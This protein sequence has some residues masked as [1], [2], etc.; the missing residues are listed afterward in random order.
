MGINNEELPI[1][2]FRE[3]IIA[4]VHD[5][6]VTLIVGSTGCGKTTQVPQ[7]LLDA[8]FGEHGIIGCT[9][10]RRAAATAIARYVARERKSN[11]G[12]EVGYHVR[13]E[14]RISE[15]TK[16]KFATSGI[17]LRETL[18]DPLLSFYSCVI[19]DEAH[20]RD[21]FNDFLLGYLW[22]VCGE[23]PAFRLVVMSATLQWQA[24]ARFFPG[25]CIIN[26]PQRRFPVEIV[27]H[28]IRDEEWLS[29][30]LSH[31]REVH[32]SNAQ[33]DI[34]VF[35]SGERDVRK[36]F[37]RVH[38]LSLKNL[39][40]FPLYGG[41]S[42]ERQQEVFERTRERKVIVA[43]NVAESSLTFDG[44]VIDMGT[45]KA[46]GFDTFFGIE[47]LDLTKISKSS[48]EQRAGRVGRIGPGKC[49]RL[50]SEDDF[51]ARPRYEEPE[52][53][54]SDL[55]NLVLIMKCLGLKNDFPFLTKPNP[56]LWASAQEQLRMYG[57]LDEYGG[58]TD[59]GRKMA[60]MPLDPYLSHFV[61]RSIAWGC[62][63]DAATL[64][65][66]LSLGRFFY[67]ELYEDEESERAQKMF[68]DEESDFFTLLAIWDAY[69]GA[70]YDAAWCKQNSLHVGWMN[71]VRTTR[72][73]ILTFLS[74]Q[75]AGN[76]TSRNRETLGKAIL[77]GF[78][79]NLLRYHRN[80]R[81]RSW[82]SPLIAMLSPASLLFERSPQFVV[83]S[84][85]FR[86]SAIFAHCNHAVPYE[87]VREIVP[88]ALVW[89]TASPQEHTLRITGTLSV[90]QAGQQKHVHVDMDLA[91]SSGRDLVLLDRGTALIEEEKYPVSLLALHGETI[92]A[93]NKAGIT[94]LAE[95]PNAKEELTAR[96]FDGETIQDIFRGIRRLGYVA[97][98]APFK[99]HES[100]TEETHETDDWRLASF[101][102][103]PLDALKCSSGTIIRLWGVDIRTVEDLVKK[104]ED[105]LHKKLRDFF[106]PSEHD[107]KKIAETMRDVRACLARFGLSLKAPERKHVLS[108][109][110]DLL[111]LPSAT[112][113]DDV[114]AE[115]IL[116]SEQFPLFKQYRVGTPPEKIE[117]RNALTVTNKGLSNK[118]VGMFLYQSRV[119]QDPAIDGDDLFQEGIIGLMR[120]I[121]TFDYTLGGRFS[122]YAMWWIRQAME[123]M[124]A[125]DALMRVPVHM[126]EKIQRL[127]KIAHKLG[128][129]PTREDVAKTMGIRIEEVARIQRTMLFQMHPTSILR[130]PEDGPNAG[131]FDDPDNVE[132]EIPDDRSPVLDIIAEEQLKRF[133]QQL[134]SERIVRD[135]DRTCLMQ[136]FGL[137]GDRAHTLEEIG[138]Y[139]GVTRERVRQRIERALEELR[140]RDVWEEAKKHLP[141]IAQVSPKSVS[142]FEVH[143]GEKVDEL[144]RTRKSKEQM[145]AECMV[146][147]ARAHQVDIAFLNKGKDI[148]RDLIPVRDHAVY[149]LVRGAKMTFE[150]VA[151]LFSLDDAF[152]AEAAYTCYIEEEKRGKGDE[153]KHLTPD[154]RW[155][156]IS[157]LVQVASTFGLTSEEIVQRGNRKE[158][159]YAGDLAIYRMREEARLSFSQIGSVMSKDRMTVIHGYYQVKREKTRKEDK[160]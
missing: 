115:E 42:P 124:V 81:Y 122:T 27:Y 146:A 32:Q 152:D 2:Q 61:L 6:Q 131:R 98:N 68:R 8:G 95:L 76:D 143:V 55:G 43:T 94:K 90:E 33:G 129:A 56:E 1:A 84:R 63:K 88:E 19:V 147:V 57:A 117:A 29:A 82:R 96:G 13:L 121:E 123:R 107:K 148:P 48:A 128:E 47:T 34:L 125:D 85:L 66:M 130:R 104:T 5:H 31:I 118:V 72:E 58:L 73:Q 113:I 28:P 158:V 112:P 151:E 101:L 10:P 120:S 17:V 153:E 103:Q 80:G 110:K 77:D 20:E 53:A 45:A 142:A 114:A 35:V 9:E 79:A 134:I 145:A 93:L 69:E 26:I 106:D 38:E 156:A 144:V 70:S 23:R 126:V 87:W 12:D 97:R 135:A 105:E 36:L 51:H 154:A 3:K 78:R 24:F 54:R 157:I 37:E 119:V 159:V 52:I 133:V 15:R 99:K 16:L 30:T 132:Y 64:A 60:A 92:A 49:V 86:T 41:M 7:F 150:E 140:T 22:R 91:R 137:E 116:G 39:T 18:I 89:K 139:L 67:R 74:R 62:A 83:A 141:E 138:N 127:K 11:V 4:A 71:G 109:K 65:A 59:H 14:K 160:V 100:P 44:C 25:A 111:A 108:I 40:C 75:G 149:E 102:K 50:Y 136:Y 155:K 46:P 21:I